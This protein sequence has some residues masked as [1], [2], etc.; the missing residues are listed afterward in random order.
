MPYLLVRRSLTAPENAPVQH[1]FQSTGTFLRDLLSAVPYAVLNRGALA[2]RENRA[3][4]DPRYPT[5]KA[6][7][8]ETQWLLWRLLGAGGCPLF[9]GD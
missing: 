3:E 8:Q 5:R 4:T 6:F 1:A 7:G 9:G 2:V